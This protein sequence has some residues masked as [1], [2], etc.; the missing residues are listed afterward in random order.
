MFRSDAAEPVA[1]VPI[2]GNCPVYAEWRGIA[3]TS[4][5]KPAG[6]SANPR[7]Q[8]STLPFKPKPL[9]VPGLPGRD[10][11]TVC[12]ED[13]WHGI[14]RPSSVR[15]SSRGNRPCHPSG[16]P[17]RGNRRRL[18]VPLFESGIRGMLGVD[19][20]VAGWPPLPARKAQPYLQAKGPLR[21][22]AEDTSRCTKRIKCARRQIAGCRTAPPHPANAV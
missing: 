2:E 10:A 7:T 9:H 5:V 16:C 19:Y 14:G 6:A 8:G 11:M 12:R 18:P 1:N 22:A 20:V 13:T 4:W 17:T 15:V 3:S 21:I